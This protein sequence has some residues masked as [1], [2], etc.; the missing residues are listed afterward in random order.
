MPEPM[1]DARILWRELSGQSALFP[2]KA[3]DESNSPALKDAI[4]R[5]AKREPVQYILG[6]VGFYREEYEVSPDCLIPRQDTEILV[7]TAVR[8]LPRGARFIDL[9]TGSGCVAISTLCN[10]SSTEATAVDVSGA[11]LEIAKR[12]A[13]K[14]VFRAGYPSR[15]LTF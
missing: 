12:N 13:E 8:L 5:R 15:S 6:K 11:A 2:P 4:E 3:E 1:A 14:M 7:D 9:C 10:T